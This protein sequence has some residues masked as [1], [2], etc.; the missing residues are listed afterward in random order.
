MVIILQYIEYHVAEPYE[1]KGDEVDAAKWAI[2]T[3]RRIIGTKTDGSNNNVEVDT[4]SDLSCVP[5]IIL[6]N[7]ALNQYGLKT[8]YF[9]P[10]KAKDALLSMHQRAIMSQTIW[11]LIQ[12]HERDEL[13]KKYAKLRKVGIAYTR[14]Q[15]LNTTHVTGQRAA[16]NY[17]R[18][19]NLNKFKHMPDIR[20][21]HKT[22]VVGTKAVAPMG[23]RYP[24]LR[25][26]PVHPDEQA[27]DHE[28]EDKRRIY[29]PQQK[30]P[31]RQ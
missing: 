9:H 17:I 31:L 29:K 3:A 23:N 13:E 21:V 11:F 4:M 27:S 26:P 19:Y 30:I 8:V 2:K 20:R 14:A 5:A 12:E 22:E 24:E 18:W 7:R 25:P 16:D 6:L 10:Q 1:V 15:V 28:V